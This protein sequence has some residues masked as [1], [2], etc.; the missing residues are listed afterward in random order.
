[1][2]DLT[3]DGAP[4]RIA[5]TGFR[6]YDVRWRYPEDIDLAGLTLLGLGVGTQMHRHGL[7][8]TIAV[9]SRIRYHF[10]LTELRP[11]DSWLLN[12]VFPLQM[13]DLTAGF[14]FY[15]WD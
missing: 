9:D 4:A 7:T 5:V 2:T 15:F 14:K 1:M 12:K 10:L 13:M 8:P 3:L 6:E 11:Y